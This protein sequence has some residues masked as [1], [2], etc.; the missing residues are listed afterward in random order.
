[1]TVQFMSAASVS[2]ESLWGLSVPQLLQEL[3]VLH[4]WGMDEQ[5]LEDK[6]PLTTVYSKAHK[7]GKQAI[8]II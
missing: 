7:P 2:C 5:H 8:K 1:M 6:K 4:P 3:S